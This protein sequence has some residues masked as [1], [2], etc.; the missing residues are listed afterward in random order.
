MTTVLLA[1]GMLM[2]RDALVALLDLETDITVVAAVSRGDA[3]LAAVQRHQPDVAVLDIDLPGQ[4]GLTV[5]AVLHTA[6][7]Q[8]RT[9]VITSPN[10]PGVVRRALDAK[11]AGFLLKDAP[12]D[13][14]ADAVRDVAAGRRVIDNDLALSA[15]ETATSPLGRRE[16]ETLGYAAEGLWSVPDF[17]DTDLGCQVG[18]FSE[19]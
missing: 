19:S 12:S 10:R 11:V 9:L 4:D 18:Q 3:V 2:L 13:Q 8:C 16:L 15:W 17:V 14:L 6:A 7:P 5:A 1:E